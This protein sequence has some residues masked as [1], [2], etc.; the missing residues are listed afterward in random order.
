MTASPIGRSGLA[1]LAPAGKWLTAL[2]LFTALL[3]LGRVADATGK[4]IGEDDL[5]STA[6]I[7]INSD[8]VVDWSPD[9]LRS[10]DDRRRLRLVQGSAGL[11]LS[12]LDVQVHVVPPV[13]M[14]D[15]T[16]LRALQGI[17]AHRS[18]QW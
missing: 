5:A 13:F 17:A 3:A 4:D 18:S 7:G 6:S 10:G 9:R 16:D 14:Q 11:G 8:V 2:A 15:P 12:Q 1:R